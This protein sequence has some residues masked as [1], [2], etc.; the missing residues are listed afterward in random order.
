[1]Y[2]IIRN[3]VLYAKNIIFKF[4]VY[5]YLFFCI[6]VLTRNKSLV[7]GPAPSFQGLAVVNGEFRDI[8]LS[9]YA[10]KYLVLFFYPLDLLVILF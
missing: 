7:H 9:D 5:I 8:K 6:S 4:I 1:M 10:G 2:C 3:Y